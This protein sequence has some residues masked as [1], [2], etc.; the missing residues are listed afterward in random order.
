MKTD[1]KSTAPANAADP[2][3]TDAKHTDA[4][5]EAAR[6]EARAEGV[7]EGRAEGVK[8]EH[9]RIRGILSHAEAKDRPMLAMS[10]AFE[11]DM[12]VEQAAKLLANS[13]KQAAG[14]A[15]ASLMAGIT[16]PKVGADA[17]IDLSAAK[18]RIDTAAIYASRRQ[19]AS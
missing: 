5:L 4:Q 10:I 9:D 13:P 14:S 18:P 7:K 19:A 1:D 12:D 17:D 11:T 2:K 3:Q 6:T 15:L 16:N 8:A